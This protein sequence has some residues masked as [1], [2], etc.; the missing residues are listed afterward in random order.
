MAVLYAAD[1]IGDGG[2]GICLKSLV[3]EVVVFPR[4]LCQRL[5]TLATPT[6]GRTLP[7]IFGSAAASS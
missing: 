4:A 1:P 2:S 5:L 6:D 3:K 7:A